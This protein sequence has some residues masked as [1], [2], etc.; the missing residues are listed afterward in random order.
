[1]ICLGHETVSWVWTVT[2]TQKHYITLQVF[3][4]SSTILFYI[5]LAC[6]AERHRS[7]APSRFAFIASK[8]N[9]KD[10]EAWNLQNDIICICPVSVYYASSAQ[11]K[12]RDRQL[13]LQSSLA[14]VL[15]VLYNLNFPPQ[16]SAPDSW[17]ETG[18][19]FWDLLYTFSTLGQGVRHWEDTMKSSAREIH[20]FLVFASEVLGFSYIVCQLIFPIYLNNG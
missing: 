14:I 17:S 2:N 12:N 19:L 9:E 3:N 18:Q 16:C 10:A 15:Q 6:T 5:N 13:S 7:P 8:S 11:L 20:W 4:F 1:M